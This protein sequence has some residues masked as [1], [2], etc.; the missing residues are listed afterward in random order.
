ME[1]TTQQTQK[2]PAEILAEKLNE[3]ITKCLTASGL[4]PYASRAYNL[5]FKAQNNEGH[6]AQVYGYGSFEFEACFGAGV[7]LTFRLESYGDEVPNCKIGMGSI[8]EHD[9]K[10]G[11]AR[12]ALYSKAVEAAALFDA[13][14]EYQFSLFTRAKDNLRKQAKQVA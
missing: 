5:P 10:L 6:N 9:A 1:T 4:L 7:N 2:S 11:A 12:A 13:A 14:A 3:N 8:G